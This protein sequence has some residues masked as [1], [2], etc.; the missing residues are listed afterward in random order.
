MLCILFGSP[1]LKSWH[2]VFCLS[3]SGICNI[4]SFIF[5]VRKGKCCVS[6][7]VHP[8]WSPGIQYNAW[9]LLGYVT[10][11]AFH[12]WSIKGNVLYPFWFTQAEVLAF[13]I[14]PVST[15]RIYNILSFS[16]MVNVGKY[17]VS[18]LVHPGWS[19]GIQWNAWVFLGYITYLVFG[20]G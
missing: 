1:R 19:H 2:S 3:T 9:A 17:C 6:F 16:F 5:V 8:G 13:S 12:S 18:Y 7:L 10:Y 11:L 14:M 4:L 20:H 15:S